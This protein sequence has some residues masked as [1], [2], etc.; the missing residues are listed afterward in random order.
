[1]F[2]GIREADFDDVADLAIDNRSRKIKNFDI[3]VFNI[4]CNPSVLTKKVII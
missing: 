4:K 3:R 1:M 2:N